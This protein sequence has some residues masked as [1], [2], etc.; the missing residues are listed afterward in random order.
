MVWR[1]CIKSKSEQI[2]GC[3]FSI[4]CFILNRTEIFVI[5]LSNAFVCVQRHLINEFCKGNPAIVTFR[6]PLI[7]KQY[8]KLAKIWFNA[9]PWD[10]ANPRQYW[11]KLVNNSGLSGSTFSQSWINNQTRLYTLRSTI[12]FIKTAFRWKFESTREK[13]TN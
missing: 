4:S 13:T 7:L 1:Q 9:L 3:I 6:D 10:D 12:V 2:L 5:R 11:F 8:F